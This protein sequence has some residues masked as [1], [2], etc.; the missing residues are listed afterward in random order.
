MEKATIRNCIKWFK[1]RGHEIRSNKGN[2]LIT[3]HNVMSNKWEWTTEIQLSEKEIVKRA[4]MY[5]TEKTG[6]Q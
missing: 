6:I 5:V 4:E 3:I 2:V 1:Q